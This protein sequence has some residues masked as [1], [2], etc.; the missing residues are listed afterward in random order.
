[1]K[2]ILAPMEGLADFYVR[3][4]LTDIGGF[5]WCV[6]EFVRVSGTLLPPKTFYRWCPEL[7]T[8]ARTRAGTSVHVQLL[9]SDPQ[10]MAENAAR[11]AELGA[12][13]IDL[14]FGCPAKTVNRHRGGAVLLDEPEVVHQ[15]V[16]A[17][18][19]AVPKHLPVSAKMRLGNCHGDFAVENARAIEAAG[20]SWLT[21]H[22]RTKVQGYKPPAY[23]DQIAL[24]RH[25]IAIPVI[26]NGEIWTADDAHRCAQ[27]SQC[28]MLM[29]GRGAV[30]DPFLAQRIQQGST[31]DWADVRASLLKFIEDCLPTSTDLQLAGR[32]KQWMNYLRR[33]WPQAQT[34]YDVIKRCKSSADIAMH[35]ESSTDIAA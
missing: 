18:R 33:D 34:L 1:M 30:S 26:A 12:P 19:N 32:L 25:A 24:L 35:I 9:G 29:L 20:A 3:Q 2:L 10:C 7:R 13:A 6:T 21:V 5:D 17:V 14:N 23:W 27:E 15:V 8:G 11:A 16:A 22:G 4:A 28:D 31:A